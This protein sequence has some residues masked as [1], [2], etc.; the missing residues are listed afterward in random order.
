[1]SRVRMIAT[2][3]D[4][5]FFNQRREINAP[6][7]E[8]VLTQLAAREAHFVIA[9]GNDLPLVNQVFG[10]FKGRF[11]YDINNGA[12]VLTANQETLH[13]A[14]FDQ[15]TLLSL[16]A[17]IEALPI[18]WRH[19]II[20]N[21]RAHSYMLE[22]YRGRGD[23][24]Q[25]ILWYFKDL[26]YIPSVSASSRDTIMKVTFNCASREASA[27]ITYFN[28]YFGQVCHATTAGFGSIDLIPAGVNKATGLRYLLE[29]THLDPGE[30]MAFGDGLND[31]E[32]LS[33]V[34]HPFAM[35]NGDPALLKQFPPALADNQHDGVL[36]TICHYLERT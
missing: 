2:D 9:T 15:P 14:S 1:M 7:F 24:Y 11:A 32:M 23:L 20:L 18:T 13:L 31:F 28:T 4:G 17:A 35:P 6:L 30:V 16:V 22:K 26:R 29:E 3:L 27:L 33:L 19:G 36:K 34:G 5:T 25:D 8:H 10:A 12:Q 21:G